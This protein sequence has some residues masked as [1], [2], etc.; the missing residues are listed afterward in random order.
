METREIGA[1][2]I[3]WVN[4]AFSFGPNI[5][6]YKM[7]DLNRLHS[8]SSSLNT[9]SYIPV[10]ISATMG[11]KYVA[12]KLGSYHGESERCHHTIWGWSLRNF[13]LPRGVD[14]QVDAK[15][16]QTGETVGLR[17]IPEETL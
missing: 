13:F 1:R 10:E 4:I 14:C 17:M 9:T 7:L 15:T 3:K 11:Q 16:A 6:N 2:D 8:Y 12:F 5:T